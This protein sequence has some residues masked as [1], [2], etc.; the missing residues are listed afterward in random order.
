[1]G[2]LSGSPLLSLPFFKDEDYRSE[3]AASLLAWAGLELF[4]SPLGYVFCISLIL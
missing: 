1:M 2:G 4:Y 3:K